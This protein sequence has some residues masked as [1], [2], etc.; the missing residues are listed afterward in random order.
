ME[1]GSTAIRLKPAAQEAKEA[2]ASQPFVPS[3]MQRRLPDIIAEQVVEA[4]RR[5]GLKPGARL[6]TEQELAQQLGV[7]RTTVRESLQKLQTLGIIEVHKGRGAFVASQRMDRSGDAFISWTAKNVFA[8]EELV[9]VRMALEAQ[10]A[11]LAAVRATGP[12]LAEIERWQEEHRA[13]GDDVDRVVQ[14]DAEF[15]EA[16]FAAS[17]NHTLASLYDQLIAEVLEFRQKTLAL[18]W[19]PQRSVKGHDEIVSAIRAR[20]PRGARRAMLD[21]LWVLYEE[22]GATAGDDESGLRPGLAMREAFG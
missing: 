19:A 9:E 21:H 22:V 14:S 10:A 12:H 17:G 15:H 7:G 18:P 5:E 13:A 8:I 11:G 1:D 16:I 6:P 2:G 20:D 3:V 4:I